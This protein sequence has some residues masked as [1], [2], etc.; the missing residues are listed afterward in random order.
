MASKGVKEKYFLGEYV[1]RCQEEN[2]SPSYNITK[3]DKITNI[4]SKAGSL[5]QGAC[6]IGDDVYY[7]MSPGGAQKGAVVRYNLITGEKISESEAF[8][9]SSEADWNCQNAGNMAYID[10]LLYITKI[11][12]S[13]LTVNPTTMEINEK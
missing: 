9:L 10:G 1:T 12:G 3:Y 8:N 5:M 2:I 4:T 13:L 7:V 11:D 6:L